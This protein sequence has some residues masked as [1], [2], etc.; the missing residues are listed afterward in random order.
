MQLLHG[1]QKLG[2]TAGA[3][4]EVALGRHWSGR[5]EY[6]FNQFGKNGETGKLDGADGSSPAAGFVDGATFNNSISSM[7]IQVVRFGLNFRF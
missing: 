1:Q 4:L 3:G 6:L 7:R 2:W 5:G